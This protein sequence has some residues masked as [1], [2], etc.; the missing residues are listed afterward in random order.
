MVEKRNV[1]L[2]NEKP[3]EINFARFRFVNYFSE[4]FFCLAEMLLQGNCVEGRYTIAVELCT[5]AT[6]AVLKGVL[7]KLYIYTYT[8]RG[9]FLFNMTFELRSVIFGFFPCIIFHSKTSSRRIQLRIAM[10][11]RKIV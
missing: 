4:V 5:I 3:R 2:L 7:V 11:T 1:W 8:S 10:T 9:F 6:R